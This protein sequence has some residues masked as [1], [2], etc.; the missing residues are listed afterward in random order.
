M[1][2]WL[3]Q[4]PGFIVALAAVFLPGLAVGAA[5]RLRGLALAALAPVGSVVVLGTLAITY[6]RLKIPW[7]LASVAI[8][9]AGVAGMA[10]LPQADASA[11]RVLEH[12]LPMAAAR[13][14]RCRWGLRRHAA[15][16]LY[17]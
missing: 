8:G 12:A 17:R 14:A 7:S 2:D 13:R 15:W 9:V 10:D 4:W 1:L 16:D 5:L 11:A 6:D 3:Q